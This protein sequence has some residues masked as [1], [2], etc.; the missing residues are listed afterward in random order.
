MK[1]DIKLNCTPAEARS[2][3]GLPDVEPLQREMM[4]RTAKVMRE[5]MTPADVMSLM[6]PFFAPNAQALEAMQQ[7]FMQNLSGFGKRSDQE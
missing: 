7:A 1:I 4:E 6:K 2:F 5:G 3:L